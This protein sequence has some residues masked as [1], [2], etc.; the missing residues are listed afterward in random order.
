M[1]TKPFFRPGLIL[2]A[3]LS[4]LLLPAVIEATNIGADPPKHSASRASDTSSSLSTSEGNL[5]EYVPV[6]STRSSNGPT[7]NVT[8]VYN[9]YNADGSRAVVD[10]VMGDRK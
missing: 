9:S 5:M 6:S 4:L 3:F 1:T 7:V 8:A 10:T 2:P